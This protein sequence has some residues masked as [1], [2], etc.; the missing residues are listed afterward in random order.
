MPN[1]CNNALYLSHEDPT[2]IDRAEKSL[3]EGKFF[4]EFL[5]CPQEL[6]DTSSGYFG[7]EGYKAELQKFTEEL[8]KK[9]FGFRDWY[10]WCNIKWGTKWDVCDPMVRRNKEDKLE[11]SFNTAWSPPM[12]FY[13]HLG[14]LGFNVTAYYYEGGMAYCGLYE[15]GQDECYEIQGNSDWVRENIPQ[16]IDY[17]FSISDSMAQWEE[18]EREEE[19]S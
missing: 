10:D 5:P 14:E 16:Y 9:Y 1:W 7:A 2:M 17:E 6:I 19:A 3:A 18:D 11:A 4:Q 8:N 13:N 12:A 15:D